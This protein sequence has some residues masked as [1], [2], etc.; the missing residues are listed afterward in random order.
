MFKEPTKRAECY[1]KTFFSLNDEKTRTEGGLGKEKKNL[2][3]CKSIWGSGLPGNRESLKFEQQLCRCR[4]GPFLEEWSSEV[5][6]GRRRTQPRQSRRPRYSLLFSPRWRSHK[7]HFIELSN[8]ST[9]S[10]KK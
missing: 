7:A 8:L 5:P 10:N 9:N 4:R 3:Y 1:H 6:N 2:N